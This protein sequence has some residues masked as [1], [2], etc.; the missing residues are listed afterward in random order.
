VR[1][2]LE[3]GA[4]PNLGPATGGGLDEAEAYRLTS[5]SGSILQSAAMNGKVETINLLLAHGAKLSN[6]AN[7]HAAVEGENIEVME[8]LITLGVDVD[9]EDS[10]K[11][12]GLP[13]YGT[14]LLR[15][16]CLGKSRSVRFYSTTELAL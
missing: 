9:Q 10:Y 16:M 5:G 7:I 3:Q 11:T 2:L 13:R 4:N 8:H 6:A 14:P 15:A 1:Y 12:M